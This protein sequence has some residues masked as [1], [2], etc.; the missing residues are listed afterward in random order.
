MKKKVAVIRK[1]VTSPCY[2]CNKSIRGKTTPRKDCKICNGTGFYVEN[3]YIH[4]VGNYAID[5]DTLK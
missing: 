4:I 5:G 3:Y 2:C 1:L